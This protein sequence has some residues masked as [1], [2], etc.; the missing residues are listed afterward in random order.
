M[1]DLVLTVTETD[2]AEIQR[3]LP[4][5][6]VAVI[7]TI[8]LSRDPAPGFHERRRN[9]L[10]F[11]GGFAH[12]PNVDA[13][14]F[15]CRDVLPLVKLGLPDLEVTIVGDKPPREI[16]DLRQSGVV[17]AG[18]VP[19]LSSLLDSH[20]VSI[21]PLR[22]GAGIKGKIGEALAAGLPVVTTTVGAE[23]MGLEHE[24]TAMIADSASAFA[25]AV[26]RLCS[27]PNLH[28]KLSESGQRHALRHWGLDS[29]GRQ[30][31]NTMDG[32]RDLRPKSLG[33]TEWIAART[34]D[35]Y[36]RSGLKSKIA[37]AESVVMWYGTQV[38]RRLGKR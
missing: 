34:L 1:A 19:E 14:L 4:E 16:Q 27:D 3:E 22:F 5:A 6:R 21:A 24:E 13:V 28:R 37:R 12:P 33:V 35:A 38:L 25:D 20:R 10:L 26:V 31:T 15:F 29:V 32:I 18:W 7:P 23:G 36:M 8:H 17:V 9:S 2:R 30:L 11:V